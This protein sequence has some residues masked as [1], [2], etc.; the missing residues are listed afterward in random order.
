LGLRL[1]K[2]SKAW[3]GFKLRNISLTIE[4]GEYFILLGPT[5]AGKTLLLETIMGFHKPDEGKIVLD[6][7]DI[8]DLSTEKRG[9]GYVPQDCVLFPHMNVRQNI[10][11]GLK[12]Q[13]TKKERQKQIVDRVLESTGLKSL[14]LCQPAT[15][16][17]GEKQK[18]ALARV[19]AI[20]PST[21]LLDEPLTGM[22]GETSRELRKELKRIHKE[23][24]TIVHVTHNQIEGF[25]LGDRMGI[26]RSGEI[27][28]TGKTKEIIAN[29]QS[30]YVAKFLGYENVFKAHLLRCGDSSSVV[31]V[32]GVK[33]EVPG[34]VE[35]AECVI[36][37]RPEDIIIVWP[38]EVSDILN[39]LE[40]KIL[41]CVDQGPFIAMTFDA[42]LTLQV[43]VTR[44][45]FISKGLEIGQKA[46]LVLKHDIIKV[47]Q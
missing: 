18:V 19:L 12:M 17:G 44:S 10:E 1:D 15:L 27:I 38:E 8:T 35:S 37:I 30:E 16:S 46:W 29:P 14:E 40:G 23:G 4:D 25:S 9:I 21:I 36:A 6:G 24:K 45:F 31:S 20:Q 2:I 22:D 33:L 11:F 13:R 34:K 43:I 3:Q 32:G 28:Q 39:V 47:I 41:D 7:V 42:G 26:I 5:G